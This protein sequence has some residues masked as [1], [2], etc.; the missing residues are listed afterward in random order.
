MTTSRL[1]TLIHH[2]T[3][4][5]TDERIQHQTHTA[6]G[7]NTST[8]KYRH[9]NIFPVRCYFRCKKNTTAFADFQL[10]RGKSYS[11]DMIS[12]KTIYWPGRRK[13]EVWMGGTVWKSFPLLFSTILP[14]TQCKLG[15]FRV[16]ALNICRRFLEHEYWR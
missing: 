9:R 11:H 8:L 15:R 5:S 2:T 16:P 6:I 10:S 14:V 4:M 1:R 13:E 12:D 7:I 3:K